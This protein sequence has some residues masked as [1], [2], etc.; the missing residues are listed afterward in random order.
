MKNRPAQ[1]RIGAIILC[2]ATLLTGAYGQAPLKTNLKRVL[3]LDKSQGGAN[4]HKESRADFN[5]ALAELA[6]EK[7][8]TVTTIGQR[9]PASIIASE[10]SMASLAN[11]QAV[12]FSNNDGVHSQLDATS[13]ANLEAYVKTG[14]GLIPMHAASAFIN[15]WPWITSVLVESFYGPFGNDQ[16]KANV[17]HDAEGTNEGTET[18][19]IFKG[20]T[21]P[22][23]FMDEF[24]SFRASPRARPD[25][26]ILL[27][28]D[29]KSY[30]KPVSGAMGED[31]PIVWS[32]AE[33]KG[34]VV[35]N[36][37]GHSWST[38]NAY[39]AKNSYLKHFLYGTLR[40]V[41]GD[42]IGCTDNAYAEYNPDATKSDPTLCA[43]PASALIRFNKDRQQSDL[44]L[45][46]RNETGTLVSVEFFMPGPNSITVTDVAGKRVYY[47]PGSGRALYSVPA[48]KWSGIYIVK[49]KAGG[50]ET[51]HRVTVL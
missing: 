41:A 51:T 1:D 31:H 24:Y 22:Q 19:G 30:T 35:S 6:A 48:P 18:Q 7:G 49:A 46:Y 11:Y 2:L 32:K 8:F 12:I 27:T 16:P 15:N 13:K 33:G 44:P 20:L 50:K 37:L 14:G 25:V 28:V 23:G 5:K 43:T 4:G 45:V 21:A 36:S 29:E 26:T 17:V 38:N 34:R 9:D 47:K 3:V 42:F 40:Y 39:T 10:F